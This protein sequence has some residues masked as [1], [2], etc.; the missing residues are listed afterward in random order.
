[1]A[2]NF[3]AF[4]ATEMTRPAA[5]NN[6]TSN[7]FDLCLTQFS[8]EILASYQRALVLSNIVKH[9]TI[10][11]GKA[12]QFPLTGRA[13]AH[14]HTA[15]SHVNMDGIKSAQRLITIP[16]VITAATMI[17]DFEQAV[18]HVDTRQEFAKQLGLALADLKELHIGMVLAQTSHATKVIDDEDQV[19]GKFITNDKFKLDGGGAGAASK[20]ELA[21]AI[22]EAIYMANV[23]MDEANVEEAGRVCV[24]PPDKYYGLIEGING[25][26]GY[27]VNREYGG[28]GSYADGTLPKIGGVQLLKSNNLPRKNYAQDSDNFKH[29]YGDFSKLVGMVFLP[30]A[31]G[32]VELMDVTVQ[33][34]DKIEYLGELVLAKHS[35]GLGALRPECCVAFELDTLTNA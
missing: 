7:L 15:G 22:C 2:T 17:D 11:G 1:M 35:Y 16:G 8:G 20:V 30:E 24:L 12:M 13:K 6:N 3:P 14:Y 5:V 19:D 10:S 26:A 34:K 33:H 21:A 25:V 18:M 29:Y 23:A 4:Q 27:A 32:C 28:S 9:R 31:M